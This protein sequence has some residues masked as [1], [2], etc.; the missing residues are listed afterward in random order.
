MLTE[1]C[2]ITRPGGNA[3]TL[4]GSSFTPEPSV[5]SEQPEASKLKTPMARVKAGGHMPWV[6]ATT[7][8][9]GQ[10]AVKPVAGPASAA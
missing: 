10:R 2:A 1:T 3:F 7:R 5:V 9:A 4:T 8:F 6:Y